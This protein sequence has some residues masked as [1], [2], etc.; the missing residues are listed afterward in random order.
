MAL[1]TRLRRLRFLDRRRARQHE[2]GEFVLA[3]E[4]HALVRLRVLDEFLDD[5]DPGRSREAVVEA[6]Y[7]HAPACLCFGIERLEFLAERAVIAFDA[8]VAQEVVLQIVEV[9]RVGH[10]D[11]GF[12]VDRRD[13]RLVAAEIVDVI[14]KPHL[15]QDRDRVGA[16]QTP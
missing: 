16:R 6:D 9:A 10:D 5:A 1:V 15:L 7:H 14:E 11:E 13:E 2:A 4:P 8:A 3:G 12:A